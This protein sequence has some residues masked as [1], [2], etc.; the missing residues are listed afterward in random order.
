MSQRL[1]YSSIS[2]ENKSNEYIDKII[3]IEDISI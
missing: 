2:N 1:I 3:F